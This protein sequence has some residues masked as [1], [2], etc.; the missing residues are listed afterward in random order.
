ML[1][2]I[3]TIDLAPD[4]TVAELDVVL[5]AGES[6]QI[7]TTRFFR[8]RPGASR[9]QNPLATPEGQPGLVM[10]WIEVEGP[11]V[12]AW[13]TASYQRLFDDL[14]VKKSV[15]SS[16]KVE[17][18]PRDVAQDSE[19]LLRRFAAGNLCLKALRA[20]ERDQAEA[21][22]GER[23]RK[24]KDQMARHGGYPVCNHRIVGERRGDE[25]IVFR[26][27]SVSEGSLHSVEG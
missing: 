9:A 11:L 25:H 10:R 6:I 27:L 16:L 12:D 14:P 2:R 20:L 17:V 23:R 8:S 19:R 5:K 7:D 3:G 18:T 21:E 13:P 15:T 22:H 4:V 1:R 24:S 26:K